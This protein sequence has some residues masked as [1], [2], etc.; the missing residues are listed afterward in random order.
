M[1]EWLWYV[2]SAALVL[3]GIIFFIV[4][5]RDSNYRRPSPVRDYEKQR[6]D[7]TISDEEEE[8]DTSE[9]DEDE[10]GD[11]EGYSDTSTNIISSS[12]IRSFIPSIFVI[13][14]V[15]G[16]C[17][18][19]I[20]G[21]V[22]LVSDPNVAANN[23]SVNDIRSLVADSLGTIVLLVVLGFVI[24]VISKVMGVFDPKPST[25][26][27]AEKTKPKSIRHYEDMRN[28]MTARTK[29]LRKTGRR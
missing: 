15:I 26:E 9:E 22:R 1:Y 6:D 10:D 27:A 14:V 18:F 25:P 20:Y 12:S 8:E 13:A 19:I 4:M 28:R 17:I 29:R 5:S 11:E 3:I 23:M 2:G 24:G 16:V 7:L 21:P